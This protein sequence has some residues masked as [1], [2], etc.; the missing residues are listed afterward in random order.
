[1][2]R[3]PL[4]RVVAASHVLALLLSPLPAAPPPALADYLGRWEILLANSGDTFRA[5][6]F[7]LAQEGGQPVG[8]LVWKW[9]GVERIAGPESIV[10]DESEGG[11]LIVRKPGWKTPLVLERFGD[12]LEGHRKLDDGLEEFIVGRLGRW[13]ANPSGEWDVTAGEDGSARGRLEVTALGAGRYSARAWNAEG[14]AVEIR[15]VGLDENRLSIRFLTGDGDAKELRL[16]AEVRGDRIEGKV[17]SDAGEVSIPVRGERRRRWGA[18]VDLLAEGLAGWRPRDPTKKFGWTC[19]GGVLANSPPDV[20]IVSNAEFRDFKVSLEYKVE[21]AGGHRSNSGIYL[22]GRYEV[23]ILDDWHED[24]AQRRVA[25]GGNGA[26]YSRIL[27]A[28]NASGA[29]GTWQKYEITLIDRFLTVVLND[30]RIIDN[31]L[32]E[33]ITGGALLPFESEPGPLMLQGDHGKIEF[34]NISVTP[35][36]P[37]GA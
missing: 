24:P 27:P 15:E 4:A 32:L 16:L 2:K 18:P 3:L 29:P 13:L 35:A 6:S 30:Q 33:G 26:V 22:R 8:K 10:L 28:K 17:E 25:P 1:V 7:V 14:A 9:G 21:R 31:Q 20:D 23:Q 19:S 12:V 34:R 36:L 11:G 37:P 5:A